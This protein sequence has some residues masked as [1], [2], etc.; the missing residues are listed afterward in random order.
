MSPDT[1]Y[2]E[3]SALKG[4]IVNR[5]R[6][7]SAWQLAFQVSTIIGIIA[8]IALLYNITNQAFGLV[9]IQNKV[10]PSSLVLAREEERLLSAANT[11]TS[12]DDNELV[13]GIAS[14]ATAIGF[15]GYA[16]YQQNSDQLKLLTVDGIAPTA[17]NVANETYPLVRPL[18]LYTTAD[19]LAQNQAANVFLNY[20]LTHVNEE[21]AD[22]GY[23]ATTDTQLSAARTAWI[24]ASGLDL[25][26]GQWA[27]INPEGISGQI[28]R[29][30]C[31]ERV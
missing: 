19:V 1:S 6:R 2:P 10:E 17:E 29:A 12:E 9:A 25:Q 15:F 13:A 14:D 31:R 30:S 27:A 18:Y 8:L 7:G 5:H 22:V 28:G 24:T 21:I 4:Q 16:Y 11:V 26:P 20:Y 23:F 3:G